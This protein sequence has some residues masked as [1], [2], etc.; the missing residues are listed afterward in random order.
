[1]I[2]VNGT[3]GPSLVNGTSGDIEQNPGSLGVPRTTT[4]CGQNSVSVDWTGTSHGVLAVERTYTVLE[5]GLF[6]LMETTLTNTSASTLTDVYF[7][8]NVDPDNDVTIGAGYATRNTIESQPS[9]TTNLAHVSATQTAND[10]SYV[11]LVAE[12]PRARVAHRGF[13]NRDASNIWNGIG[14]SSAVGATRNADEAIAIAFR[15]NTIAPARRSTSNTSTFLRT[16]PR[17]RI[18][19]IACSLPALTWMRNNSS[20]S[21]ITDGYKGYFPVGGAAVSIADSDVAIVDDDF[22]NIQRATVTLT[23]AQPGDVLSAATSSPSWPAGIVVNGAST[24]SNII[25]NGSASV[26]AY[27]QALQ[28]IRF[29]NGLAAPSQVDRTIQVQVEDVDAHVS[30]VAIS[31]IC[32]SDVRATKEQIGTPVRNAANPDYWDVTFQ[33][34]IENTGNG[35]LTGLDLVE[36]LDAPGNFGAGFVSANPVSGGNLVFSGS[37]TAP[38]VNTSWNGAGVANLLSDDG[39]LNP[40]DSFTLDFTATL[41]LL[42]MADP[43]TAT[44]QATVSADDPN[45]PTNESFLSDASDSG[46]T[47]GSTNDGAPGATPGNEN[48]PTPLILRDIE[49][50]KAWTATA[51]AASGTNGNFDVTYVFT[52]ENSGT[53]RLSNLSLTDNLAAQFGG[54]Q[55]GVVSVTVNNVSATNPP[56]ANAA[57]N[58]TAGSDLLVPAAANDLRTGESFQVVLVVELDP[59]NALAN[60]NVAGQLA[61]SATAQAT[62]GVTVVTDLSDDP[63][64][65]ADVDSEGDNEADDPTGIYLGALEVTKTASTVTPASLVAGSSGTAG[66]FVVDFTVTVFNRGND[67]IDN[68]SLDENLASQYGGAF[69]QTIGVPT[70]AVINNSGVA[71]VAAN[72]AGFNGGTVSELFNTATSQLGRGDQ[73]QVVVRVEVDPD[74][75]TAALTGGRLE[76]SATASGTGSSGLVIADVSDD[77]T[78]ATNVDPNNDNNPDD[79]T[80][81]SIADL[82]AFKSLTS[83]VPSGSGVAGNFDVTYLFRV[84]NTGT[85]TLSQLSLTDNFASQ[86]G[87]AFVGVIGLS[88]SNVDATTP[89][90]ANAGYNG[91]AGS[92]LLVP[93]AADDVGPGQSFEVSLTIEVDPDNGLASYNASGELQNIATASGVGEHGGLP[94]GLSDNVSDPTDAD[95]DSDGHPNDP[96]TLLVADMSVTKS[97]VASGPASSG[98]AGNFD[99]TYDLTIVNTGNDPLSALSLTDDLFADMGTAFVGIVLQAGQPATLQ[100]GSITDNPEWNAAFDGNSAGVGD[101]EI[102][103]NSGGNTNLLGVGESLTIRIIAEIDPDAAGA[104]VAGGYVSNQATATAAGTAVVISQLSDDPSDSTDAN[105]VGDNDPE[106][107]TRVLLSDITL[108][109]SVV[110]TPSRQADGTWNVSF[111]VAYRNTGTSA[112]SNLM[113]MDDLSSAS[114]FG[115]AWLSTTAVSVDAAGV[116]SGVAPGLNAA[117]QVD[118]TVNV[119]DGTGSLEP[120]D[121][122]V[123]NFSVNIDPDISGSTAGGITNQARGTGTDTQATLVADF[124]DDPSNPTN[125]DPNG[126]NDP[127]DATFVPLSDI[128]A[129]KQINSAVEVTGS[130]GVFDVEY[131]VVIENTGTVDLT[132]VQVSEQLGGAAGHF[133]NG[134]LG[135]QTSPAIVSSS[136]SSGASLPTLTAWDGVANS[137]LFDGTSGLLRPGDSFVVT[138]TV[139]VDTVTGDTTAPFD[140]NNQIVATADG[141]A[142]TI[143]QRLVGLWNQSQRQQYGRFGRYTDSPANSPDSLSQESRRCD[144]QSRR[145]VYRAG[146][147]HDCQHRYRRYG[148]DP[149]DRGRGKSVWRRVPGG[150]ESS[151]SAGGSLCR[152]AAHAQRGMGRRYLS[153][154]VFRRGK[155]AARRPVTDVHVRRNRRS[156]CR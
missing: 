34:T 20:G 123:V 78:N 12:D 151:D 87:G 44:N 72:P 90:V 36:A 121:E 32:I 133:G 91:L 82:A 102:I 19:L 156:R 143:A 24:S 62:S 64:N 152:R 51:P 60:Y 81:I 109:K 134:F 153:K 144:A 128:G 113:L 110:G 45:N 67:L 88:V 75:A 4:Q 149:D 30:N 71:G 52:V 142:S 135:V 85:E 31:T 129:S 66:H 42:A 80:S 16:A 124:S 83:I 147:H 29:S 70:I 95:S 93:S 74:A 26:T 23:N 49:V 10:G 7:A 150:S 111:A 2:E 57:Y 92:N 25:L 127:D 141:P 63:A 155:F 145:L 77:P 98:T 53:E 99:I 131:A 122:V 61:N 139:R 58:G 17:S 132:N 1:M 22:S 108:E 119:F 56:A 37:G 105:T 148:L 116:T 89:P 54:A 112:I 68:L 40:G 84:T 33:L 8:H 11:A 69:V 101:A 73:V 35:I 18:H 120:G 14:F 114:N 104:V 3:S 65:S 94:V 138:F 125:V 28:L 100:G 47:P 13:D 107:V 48:D 146:D 86:F 79:P 46:S 136:L 96:T 126:D 137:D 115:A 39:L 59:D 6:I 50:T 117:W 76:N 21:V 103:D 55:V 41:D 140:F 106:D 9:G 5:D 130:T 97:F 154:R 38:T 118:P 43:E 15:F 27:E